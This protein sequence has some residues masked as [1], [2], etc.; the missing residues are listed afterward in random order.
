M[1]LTRRFA[2]LAALPFAA[3]S[4]GTDNFGTTQSIDPHASGPTGFATWSD[5][6][7]DY[8]FGPGDHLRISFLLTPEMNE[9]VT[10]APD[11]TVALRV[12][13][14][15]MAMN[16]TEAELEAAIAQ[17][18]RKVLNNPVVTVAVLDA[19]SARVYVGGSVERPGAYA[20]TTRVDPLEIITVAGGFTTE[21][22]MDEV[23]LI[24]RDADNR[25]MLR[26]VD[27]RSFISH[28]TA[29]ADLPLYSGDIVFVPRNRISEVDLW[30]DQ[31]INKLLP[32]NKAF[33]YTINRN[34][35]PI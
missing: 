2:L 8:R 31:F 20:L 33:S 35:P 7:P 23:V 18:S 5:A 14:K 1:A 28:A 4:G 30:I 12:A 25:P 17:S 15:V 21:A 13:G 27:L 34:Q 16:R 6:V 29:G 3:C 22:R 24:R 19:T 11:G 32:F 9:D 26:T 10:V